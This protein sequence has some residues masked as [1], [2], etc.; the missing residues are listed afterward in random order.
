MCYFSMDKTPMAFK[1]KFAEMLGC[2]TKKKKISTKTPLSTSVTSTAANSKPAYTKEE[3]NIGLVEDT[4][5]VYR[6]KYSKPDQDKSASNFEIQQ[7]INAVIFD[8]QPQSLAS[9]GEF[10]ILVAIGAGQ[11]SKSYLMPLRLINSEM[12]TIAKNKAKPHNTTSDMLKKLLYIVLPCG[13]PNLPLKIMSKKSKENR[14]VKMDDGEDYQGDDEDQTVSGDNNQIPPPGRTLDNEPLTPP[15]EEDFGSLPS[16]DYLYINAH[17]DI[18]CF[19]LEATSLVAFLTVVQAVGPNVFPPTSIAAFLLQAWENSPLNTTAADK[20]E[21]DAVFALGP[22]AFS[23]LTQFLMSVYN[24]FC[25]ELIDIHNLSVIAAQR[26]YYHSVMDLLILMKK[27]RSK[28]DRSLWDPAGSFHELAVL[29][30][31]NSH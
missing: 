18:I 1:K 4:D 17:H 15:P 5:A 3:W 8:L 7:S 24:I 19:M 10:T 27:V 23:V 30:H 13:E 20:S 29:L 2:P 25:K 6:E 16:A 14:N 11:G 26:K 9:Y 22:G 28:Y 12:L 21:F 31:K